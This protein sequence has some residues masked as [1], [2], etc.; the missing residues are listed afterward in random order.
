MKEPPR[1]IS[2]IKAARKEFLKFPAAVQEIMT[3]T[4]TIAAK[5]EKAAIT[6]PMRGLGSGIF[7]I[8]YP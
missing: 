1:K 7:E 8:A 3:D 4:L 5:G 2:W 6:K